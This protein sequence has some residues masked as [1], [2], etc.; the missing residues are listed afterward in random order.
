MS[1]LQTFS[2]YFAAGNGDKIRA[3]GMAGQLKESPLH[4]VCWKHFLGLIP[5]D[6]PP[7]EWAA[8][9][10]EKRDKYEA[11]KDEYILD[12]TKSQDEDLDMNNPLSMNENSA[13]NVY[14]ENTELMNEIKKDL[15]R[16]YPTGCDEFFIDPTINAI[17]L[18]SLFVWSK[19]HPD[20]SY[21]QGMHELLAP[22]IFLFHREKPPQAPD[23][24]AN[25]ETIMYIMDHA[26]IEHDAFWCFMTL[27]DQMEPFFAVDR[28]PK[29]KPPPRGGILD[30]SLSGAVGVKSIAQQ[31][32][33]KSAILAMG[34]RIQ[35]ELLKLADPALHAKLQE[36]GIEHQLYAMRWVRLIFG[37][38]F[39]IEDLFIIWDAIFAEIPTAESIIPSLEYFSVSMLLYVREFMLSNEG[40]T[41]MRRLMKYPPVEDVTTLILRAQ[42]M[43]N[44][45]NEPIF[46]LNPAPAPAFP[47]P[48]AGAG[49]GAPG[50]AMPPP[51]PAPAMP[52]PAVAAAAPAAAANPFTARSFGAPP[53]PP[54][55]AYA[56]GAGPPSPANSSIGGVA[57]PA[58]M[59][60]TA[61][62]ALQAGQQ[63]GQTAAAFAGEAAIKLKQEA[64]TLQSQYAHGAGPPAPAPTPSAAGAGP[65]LFGGGGPNSPANAA[66]VRAMESQLAT[67]KGQN[68]QLGARLAS[69]CTT[70]ETDLLERAFAAMDMEAQQAVNKNNIQEAMLGLKQVSE[71][72]LGRQTFPAA[73]APAPAP[74]STPALPPGVAMPPPQ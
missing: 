55:A 47:P 40:V 20:T 30:S 27:M 57:V 46:G 43:R 66:Q 35:N 25:D 48:G 50:P 73:A 34:D 68:Q 60:K 18:N 11:L 52:A 6:K 56:A 3:M 17:M 23:P 54:T 67:L 59:Q 14:H 58:W 37:R 1:I 21:R 29:K 64:A 49:A 31:E 39:H 62:A 44:M 36:A 19:M 4:S 45:P 5:N 8:T 33:T 13:W 42:T 51:A 15:N 72:L 26:Y 70:L 74:S 16:L 69:L 9:I 38:E 63:A 24:A 7:S 32:A 53:P 71:I 28:S 12:P 10:K 61:Q 65:A 41:C 2:D 22:I